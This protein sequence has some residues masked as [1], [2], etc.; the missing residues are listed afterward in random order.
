MREVTESNIPRLRSSPPKTRFCRSQEPN[1][2]TLLRTL[3]S[4]HYLTVRKPL[5]NPIPIFTLIFRGIF[6]R[7]QNHYLTLRQI[8]FNAEPL[9][10]RTTRVAHPAIKSGCATLYLLH[11]QFPLRHSLLTGLQ[12][13]T[14]GQRNDP[15]PAGTITSTN[16]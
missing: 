1:A 15:S 14:R 11:K 4:A 8:L 13:L 16:Q 2:G 10:M 5:F 9:M 12:G 3:S 7:A 6:G